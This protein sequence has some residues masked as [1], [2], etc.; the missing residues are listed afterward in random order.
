MKNTPLSEKLILYFVLLG[1]GAILIIS[2]VSF[3]STKRALM[4]RTFDQLTSLRIVKK[5]QIDQ[6]YAD[7]VR[8]ITFI[9]TAE[10]G[11]KKEETPIPGQS[12]G[13]KRVQQQIGMKYRSLGQYFSAFYILGADGVSDQGCINDSGGCRPLRFPEH[14]YLKLRRQLEIGRAHV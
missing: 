3:Y 5:N 11:K 7:R 8:D 6:F 13:G 9:A 14:L 10:E 12:P 2:T 1:L 4:S